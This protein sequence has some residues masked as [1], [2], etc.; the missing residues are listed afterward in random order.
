LAAADAGELGAQLR[1]GLAQALKLAPQLL[2]LIVA[3]RQPPALVG[4]PRL[5]FLRATAEDFGFY[6]LP[7]ELTF[8]IGD[9]IGQVADLA[10]LGVE[11]IAGC[12]GIEAFT[13]ETVLRGLELAFAVV[14]A[15]LQRI[16][17]GAQRDQLDALAVID[18]GSLIEFGG[19]LGEIHLFLRQRAFGLAHG[20]EFE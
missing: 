20:V 10:A 12:R 1:F 13:A 7:N 19:E 9:T 18:Y 4:E 17:L 14:D 3:L 11:Q 6:R 5:Q 15:I 8:E 2:A 16:N